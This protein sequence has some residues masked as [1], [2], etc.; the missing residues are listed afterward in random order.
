MP[1]ANKVEDETVEGK[2]LDGSLIFKGLL[3]GRTIL[4]NEM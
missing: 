1:L 4:N 2:P 3:F